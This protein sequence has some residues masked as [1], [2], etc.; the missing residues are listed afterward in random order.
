MFPVQYYPDSSDEFIVRYYEILH[1]VCMTISDMATKMSCIQ[2]GEEL[3]ARP[4]MMETDEKTEHSKKRKYIGLE[5]SHSYR[6]LLQT[7]DVL[8]D[9][10]RT[11]SQSELIV[12]RTCSFMLLLCLI[13]KYESTSSMLDSIFDG[14]DEWTYISDKKN[15]KQRIAEIPLESLQLLLKRICTTKQTDK[16]IESKID[17]WI[18]V[19]GKN[20]SSF[21]QLNTLPGGNK[22]GSQRYTCVVTSGSDKQYVGSIQILSHEDRPECMVM[23]ILKHPIAEKECN[24]MSK[25]AGFVKLVFDTVAQSMK[26]IGKSI[27]WTFPLQNMARILEKSYGKKDQKLSKHIISRFLL[28]MGLHANEVRSILGHPHGLFVYTCNELIL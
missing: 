24:N 5:E 19:C 20:L 9:S 3:Y 6:Q 25:Y 7:S 1:I 12:L 10:F 23:G 14:G 21:L 28:V 18:E 17:N 11:I 22:P 15:L 4:C 13:H 27:I 8:F 16:W 2:C 26:K